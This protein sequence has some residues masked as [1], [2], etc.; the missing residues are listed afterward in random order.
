MTIPPFILDAPIRRPFETAKNPRP[1][2]D[3]FPWREFLRE[4]RPFSNVGLLSTIER[5]G[6]GLRIALE[7][8]LPAIGIMADPPAL[9][10]LSL[11]NAS[12]LPPFPCH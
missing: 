7:P 6:L 1:K 8:L 12:V 3:I 11:G 4:E 9:A 5:L 10:I 2:R